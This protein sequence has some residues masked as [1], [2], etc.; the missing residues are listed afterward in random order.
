MLKIFFNEGQLVKQGDILAEID[1]KPLKAQYSQYQGQLFKDQA[2]LTNAKLLSLIKYNLFI[3]FFLFQKT[4]YHKF[5][6]RQ[7]F[8]LRFLP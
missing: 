1:S 6:K 7:K 2:F 3:L 4:I 5:L 8:N